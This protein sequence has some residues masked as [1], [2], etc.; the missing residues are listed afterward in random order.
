MMKHM[1]RCGQVVV[2]AALMTVTVFQ[3]VELV[4]LKSV[5]F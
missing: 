5:N 2:L 3:N 4:T 1:R